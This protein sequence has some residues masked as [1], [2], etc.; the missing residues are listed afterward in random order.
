MRAVVTTGRARHTLNEA[1]GQHLLS[2][3]VRIEDCVSENDDCNAD[4]LELVVSGRADRFVDALLGDASASV[5]EQYRGMREAFAAIGLAEPP[6]FP[7]QDLRGRILSSLEALTAPRAAVLVFDMLNDHLT[8]GRPLEVPRARQIVPA[9]AHRLDS[10]RTLGIPVVYVLDEHD[11]GDTDLDAWGTHNLRGTQGA[12]VWPALAPKP[13]DRV[14]RKHT[15]SAFT[16]SDLADVLS[17]L[18]VDTLVLTGCLTE[19]GI[20]ATAT[21]ALQR[22]YAI[23]IPTDAQAGATEANENLALGILSVLPPYGP[24]RAGLLARLQE[25]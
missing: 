13:T 14:V 19:V 21:D 22:G 8:P 10:A 2:W 17:G 15:Y 11:P 5:K 24:A 3:I 16:G 25:T 6:Q 9:L 7:S 4:L 12:E 23:E 20:M 18:G 1:L